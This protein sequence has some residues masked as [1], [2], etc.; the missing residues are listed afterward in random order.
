MIAA[1]LGNWTGLGQ[2]YMNNLNNWIDHNG[3]VLATNPLAFSFSGAKNAPFIGYALSGIASP[4]PYNITVPFSGLPFAI[5]YISVASAVFTS[6]NITGYYNAQIPADVMPGSFTPIFQ[7]VAESLNGVGVNSNIRMP[8]GCFIPTASALDF[9]TNDW[10]H[11]IATDPNKL[12]KTPFA[13]I[14]ATVGNFDHRRPLADHFE[15]AE[16]IMNEV[17]IFNAAVEDCE[18]EP[19]PVKLSSFLAKKEGEVALLNWTT[20]S[21][22]NFDRFSIERSEDGKKWVAIG[23]VFPKSDLTSDYSFSDKIPLPG[24]NYYRLKMVD[25]DGSFAYS[26]IK[27]VAFDAKKIFV[28]PNPADSDDRIRLMKGDQ[29]ISEIQIYNK[30]GK[31]VYQ[32]KLPREEI[33]IRKLLSGQYIMKVIFENGEE[34]SQ[35]FIKK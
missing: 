6:S 8:N 17:S 4:L 12:E 18:D 28:Y 21:E 15:L 24:A 33:D 26:E 34:N 13:S 25:R 22:V 7:L 31:Q 35:V 32:S 9:D 23:T 2:A 27:E 10:Y 11:N 29:V 1:S 5:M 16:W 14:F 3:S 20:V 30:A 19:L